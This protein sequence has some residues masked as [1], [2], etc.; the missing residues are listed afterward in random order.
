MADLRTFL[1]IEPDQSTKSI[2]KQFIYNLKTNKNFY[3]V[4]WVKPENLHI[5]LAFL[6]KTP[7]SKIPI[8]EREIGKVTALYSPIKIN[9]SNLDAFP[10]WKKPKILWIG[11]ENNLDLL[12]I[13]EDIDNK[14]QR[15]GFNFDKRPFLPHITIGRQKHQIPNKTIEEGFN[16]KTSFVAEK[17]SLVRSDLTKFGPI[18]TTIFSKYFKNNI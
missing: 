7:K 14:L 12:R 9:L 16:L 6:G 10:N 3:N 1:S 5:T 4:R 11:I 8:L 2:I 15:L 13:K 18:Y 17:I